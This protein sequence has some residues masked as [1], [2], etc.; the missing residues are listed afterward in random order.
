[1]ALPSRFRQL[2]LAALDAPRPFATTLAQE[3]LMQN[4]FRYAWLLG[5]AAVVCGILA[6]T[7]LVA[8]TAPPG[9]ASPPPPAQ[10]D[11]KQQSPAAWAKSGGKN[12]E[13]TLR[14]LKQYYA[15]TTYGEASGQG[16]KRTSK[17]W[18]DGERIRITEQFLPNR[19]CDVEIK[20][21]K[22]CVYT[23]DA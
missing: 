22:L 7:F 2:A 12:H 11:S 10:E 18:R 20:E 14:H 21:G 13:A 23:A 5:L 4:T 19:R 15:E 3:I 16:L 17:Y 9:A 6:T 1:S 8:Q